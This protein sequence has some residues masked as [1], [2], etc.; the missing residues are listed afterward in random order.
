MRDLVQQLHLTMASYRCSTAGAIH[1][2]HYG[3]LVAPDRQPFVRTAASS[4]VYDSAT[5]WTAGRSVYWQVIHVLTTC[6]LLAG[7]V[8]P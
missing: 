4:R 6:R 3:H 1:H 2:E 5:N 8:Q 7:Q